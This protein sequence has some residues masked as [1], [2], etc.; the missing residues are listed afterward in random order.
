MDRVSSPDA[1]L[2]ENS[3]AFENDQVVED[4]QDI[5]LDGLKEDES[6]LKSESIPD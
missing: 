3:N 5:I 2:D 6:E 1:L 4:L